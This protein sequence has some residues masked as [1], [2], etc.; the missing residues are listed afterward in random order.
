MI[1]GE[2]ELK[3]SHFQGHEQVAGLRAAA[4]LEI[5]QR[6]QWH[7]RHPEARTAVTLPFGRASTTWPMGELQSR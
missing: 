6:Q 2:W 4:S 7:T 1:K 5:A 3:L